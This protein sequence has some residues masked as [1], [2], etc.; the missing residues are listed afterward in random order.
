MELLSLWREGSYESH[1]RHGQV[2]QEVVDMAPEQAVGYRGLG[3]YY[4]FLGNAGKSPKESYG[5]A[6]K[7]AQKAL[8]IDESDPLTHGL[9]GNIYL[10]MRQYEKAI[11]TGRRAIELEPNGAQVHGLL[12]LTLSFAGKP[13][14]GIRYLDQAIRLN[15]FPANWYYQHLGRCYRVKGQYDKALIEFKKA[16]QLSPKSAM[17]NMEIV[18]IYALLDRQEDAEAAAKKLLKVNPSFSVKRVSKALPYKNQADIQP[19]ADA[20]RKA[21]LP[22]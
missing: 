22:E 17:N 18:A 11:E 15:P 9:L 1:M 8:S 6:F 4:W 21:G 2:A 13:D 19:F 12:G 14:E 7:F 3:W 10:I 5:K 20:L 16:L